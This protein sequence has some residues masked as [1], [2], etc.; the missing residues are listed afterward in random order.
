MNYSKHTYKYRNLSVQDTRKHII[1]E[2]HR[3][4]GIANEVLL[5]AI[6]RI[7]KIININAWRL[8][9]MLKEMSLFYFLEYKIGFS[10]TLKSQ[11]MLCYIFPTST[12]TRL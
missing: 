4:F 5:Q 10:L 6:S 1:W 9:K 11:I 8:N 2:G 12:F 7:D 3:W